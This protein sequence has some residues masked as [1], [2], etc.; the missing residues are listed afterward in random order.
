MIIKGEMGIFASDGATLIA[1]LSAGAS[2]GEQAVVGTKHRMATAKAITDTICL[3]IPSNMLA[4]EID[5]ATPKLKQA[6]DALTL[7][8]LGKNFVTEMAEI[9][10]PNAEFF[11]N[12]ESPGALALL[13]ESNREVS[14]IF[15]G[16]EGT[17]NEL[18]KSGKGVVITDGEVVIHK[19]GMK[20]QFKRGGA[21]GVA[22]VIANVECRDAFHLVSS[23]NALA[24]DGDSAFQ[25]FS[26]L[27]PGLKGVVKGLIKRALGTDAI[28]TGRV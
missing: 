16:G 15:I 10:K 12:D 21:L 9:G 19:N 22:E 1:T 2:F 14:T 20:C 13:N 8:L 23:V 7:Q 27:S 18:I 11:V 24:I 25:A 3:E 28:D 26:Q 4:G 6:F 5:K 17:I